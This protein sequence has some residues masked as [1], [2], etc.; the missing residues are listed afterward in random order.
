MNLKS[1]SPFLLQATTYEMADGRSLTVGRDMGQSTV[2][3]NK[4]TV[5]L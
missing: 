4:L 3:W 5:C 2:T 1:S